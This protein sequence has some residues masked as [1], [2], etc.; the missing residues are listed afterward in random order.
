MK[1]ALNSLNALDQR[2][3]I[4]MQGKTVLLV[5]DDEG[6]AELIRRHSSPNTS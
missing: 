3:K 6:H 2:G 4:A 5:E 1:I